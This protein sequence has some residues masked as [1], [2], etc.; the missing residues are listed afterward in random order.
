MPFTRQSFF[1]VPSSQPAAAPPSLII[2]RRV[3]R[4]ATSSSTHA[5][6]PLFLQ[7]MPA[8]ASALRLTTA[9]TQSLTPLLVCVAPSFAWACARR[10]PLNVWLGSGLRFESVEGGRWPRVPPHAHASPPPATTRALPPQPATPA[11][12][13]HSL[14]MR[15]R[16]THPIPPPPPHDTPTNTGSFFF[17]EAAATPP[18]NHAKSTKLG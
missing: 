14:S 13:T 18:R 17:P 11:P 7:D 15:Q 3:R 2:T 12:H 1:E 5:G 16:L 9:P 4:M 6:H 10:G 8:H